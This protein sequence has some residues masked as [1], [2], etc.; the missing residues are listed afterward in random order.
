MISAALFPMRLARQILLFA[1]RILHR[2]FPTVCYLMWE[3]KLFLGFLPIGPHHFKF[4][5]SGDAERREKEIQR[6]LHDGVTL[7]MWLPLPYAKR[8]E[9]GVLH[10]TRWAQAEMPAHSGQTE[11]RIWYNL[12]SAILG[13]IAAYAFDGQPATVFSVV[14]ILSIPLDAILVF[15]LLAAFWY[16]LFAAVVVFAGWF[17]LQMI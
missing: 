7:V 10:C 12:F 4:G 6:D 5:V 8:F 17:I 3:K 1:R 11:W 14:L 9:Q 16:T 15:L 13:A 2:L